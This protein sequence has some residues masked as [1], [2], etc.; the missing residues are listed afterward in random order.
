MPSKE[1][2]EYSAGIGSAA[3]TL[4][5]V[6]KNNG[7]YIKSS[8]G[9]H[10]SCSDCIVKIQSGEDQITEPTFEEINLL[11]NV[12]HITKERLSCQTKCFGDVTVDISMH[13][14]MNDQEQ[15]RQKTANVHAKTVLRRTAQEK[16]QM[17]QER[18]E[19][20]AE[21]NAGKYDEQGNRLKDGGFNRPK[22]PFKK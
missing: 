5:E 16:D 14:K 12:F 21:R 15:L 11:G 19:K 18:K 4:L 8:C 6:L 2:F 10:A 7:H 20:S 17:I 3:P 13:N 1:S 22:D 9:G